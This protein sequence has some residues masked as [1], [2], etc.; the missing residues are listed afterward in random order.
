MTLGVILEVPDGARIAASGGADYHALPLTDRV[1]DPVRQ[2]LQQGIAAGVFVPH[3][4]GQCHYWPPALM[5]ASRTDEKVRAWLESPAP[6]TTETLPSHLQSR[7]V[8]ASVLPSC[9]LSRDAISAAVA[10][11]VATF[12]AVF[13]TPPQVAVATTFVWNA[14]VESAWR[15]SGV[16][17]IVTPGRRATCRDA[18]GQPGGVDATML[19]GN[20]SPAGQTYLVRDVYFEPA[21]GHTPQRLLDGLRQR[22]CQGRACL[23]E[24]HRF[25]F[26]ESA[27]SFDTLETALRAALAAQP[28][29][30]FVTPLELA[31]AMRQRDP[32]WIEARF[33]PRLTAWRARLDEIPHF[34]RIARWSG[35]SWRCRRP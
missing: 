22:T 33:L 13:G 6:A 10:A 26:L 32:Q 25:N 24:T 19:A 1:F 16:A 30:R 4:H 23:A 34:A 20:R 28:D 12:H 8:D 9:A 31:R 29:V 17:A 5:T 27:D 15:E 2:A 35:L 14:A 7:W 11:E 21:Y 3:L 18:G